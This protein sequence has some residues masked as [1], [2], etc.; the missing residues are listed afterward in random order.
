LVFERLGG[1]GH[2]ER[3][4]QNAEFAVIADAMAFNGL[5][6]SNFAPPALW[7]SLF[8]ISGRWNMKPTSSGGIGTPS[9]PHNP[10]WR[11]YRVDE[12][13]EPLATIIEIVIRTFVE[14]GL[15]V[16]GCISVLFEQ[17]YLVSGH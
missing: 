13:T 10:R 6:T 12:S 3:I 4:L 11:D 17:Y 8:L 15:A 1:V 9:S 5:T 2:L 16:F 7:A 14:I